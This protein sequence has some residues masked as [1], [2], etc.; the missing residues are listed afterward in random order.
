MAS[1]E[2]PAAARQRETQA[3]LKSIVESSEAWLR[4]IRQ[5]Q[6]QVRLATSF[7]TAF[8]F[9][10]IAAAV[11]FAV[12]YSSGVRAPFNFDVVAYWG[13]AALAAMLIGGIATY[14]LLKRKQESQIKD[15]SSLIVQM[16]GRISGTQ[17]ATTAGAG[18]IE[19]AL[20]LADKITALL[21]DLVRKRNQD[22]LLF[23]VAAFI[24][25]TLIGR[26]AA[27][28]ILV[29]VIVW[30]YF[31]YEMG[32]TYD[33]EIARFEEQKKNLEQRKQD[34]LETL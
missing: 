15:L 21:P 6:F 24:F 18:I 17:D 14:F 32:K 27:V 7:L 13:F 16:K 29:G 3:D 30:L 10:I 31:R 22:T 8:L 19:D 28:G 2:S 1:S 11:G 12:I 25:A 26:N 4:R 5:R 20:A 23:G 33:R 9:L 34:F